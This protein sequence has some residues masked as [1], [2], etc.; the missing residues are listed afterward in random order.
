MSKRKPNGRIE[1]ILI[2]NLLILVI[3]AKIPLG[4]ASAMG[5]FF[6]EDDIN[7]AT[8]AVFEETENKETFALEFLKMGF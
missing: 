8:C 3:I 4:D 1:R 6:G 7:I 5:F 2:V